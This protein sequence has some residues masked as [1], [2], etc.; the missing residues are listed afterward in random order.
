MVVNKFPRINKKGD[1]TTGLVRQKRKAG[2]LRSP[3]Q[4]FEYFI[5]LASG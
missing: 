2:L 1:I 4:S 3:A 5:L